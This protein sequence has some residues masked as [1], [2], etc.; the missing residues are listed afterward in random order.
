MT[1]TKLF[2]FIGKCDWGFIYGTSPFLQHRGV[3]GVEG[4]GREMFLVMD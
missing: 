4:L 2:F 3:I 1:S